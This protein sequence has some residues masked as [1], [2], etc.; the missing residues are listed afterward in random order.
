MNNRDIRNFL[1]PIPCQ[2]SD[3]KSLLTHERLGEQLEGIGRL[4]FLIDSLTQ[5]R[6]SLNEEEP[7]VA[8]FVVKLGKSI[9]KEERDKIPTDASINLDHY[10]YGAP[11]KE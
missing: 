9:P 6:E 4:E 2:I 3:I 11:K 7:D 8:D 1:G 5:F 10:L